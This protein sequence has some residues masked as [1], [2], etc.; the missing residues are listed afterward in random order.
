MK[1]VEKFNPVA[2]EVPQLQKDAGILLLL[3]LLLH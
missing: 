2:L 1:S 3:L